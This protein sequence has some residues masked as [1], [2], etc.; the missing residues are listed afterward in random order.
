MSLS[1]VDLQDYRNQLT[2]NFEQIDHV[3]A[4]CMSEAA[5]YLSPPGPASQRRAPL[6]TWTA[7]RSAV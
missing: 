7:P 4:N 2:C 3:F 6:T 1:E 5:A